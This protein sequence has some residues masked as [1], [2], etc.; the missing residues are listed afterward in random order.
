MKQVQV[1]RQDGARG[2]VVEPLRAENEAARLVIAFADGARVVVV[3]DALVA[4]P[5]GT[6]CVPLDHA[7]AEI[8]DRI[9]VPL[10][11]EELS[12][13]KR[14]VSTGLVR[15]QR[16]VVTR[17]EVVDEPL[18]REDATVERVPVNR[19]VEGDAPVVRH[20]H[21]VLVIPVLE[22]VL[23]V[24]KRLMLTEEVR[25]T[26]RR[27]QHSEPQRVTLRRTVVDV[28][29]LLPTRRRRRLRTHRQSAH[30]ITADTA[31]PRAQRSA[32]RRRRLWVGTGSAPI[33][34]GEGQCKES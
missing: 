2:T 13:H 28:A 11:I 24:E 4:R 9:V 34:E 27:V 29:G 7:G 12:V 17:E 33:H 31:A 18:M 10:A 32:T 14:E 16:R 1:V 22:E 25:V 8:T 6:C 5:D 21:G 23:I 15:L 30:P 3:E 26:R 20:E 19:L